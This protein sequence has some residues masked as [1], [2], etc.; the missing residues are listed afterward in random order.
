MKKFPR[1]LLTFAPETGEG[2]AAPEGGTEPAVATTTETP[3]AEGATETPPATQTLNPDETLVPLSA[4]LKRVNAVQAQ[5]DKIQ[6]ELEEERKK[7]AAVQ[8]QPPV[9]PVVQPQ[10]DF[11]TAVETAV[12]VKELQRNGDK[13][14]NEG[15]TRFNDFESK[16][17]TL[18]STYG[19]LPIQFLETLYETDDPAAV[20]YEL[21]SD[22]SKAASIL[23]LPPNKQGIA[24]AKLETAIK[25]K[26]AAKPKVPVSQAPP[27]V[28][29]KVQSSSVATAKSTSDEGLSTAE[30][31]ALRNKELAERR[32]ATRRA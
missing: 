31:M 2:T 13:T 26:P 8:Q 11:N 12:K 27:P 32:K 1:E 29:A 17:Q 25:A 30:W 3:P 9:V 5:K 10:I 4:M 18:A 14:Y 19:Q 28:Q 22:L 15:K 16:V 21:S 20:L 6:K 24:L 7:T 23:D